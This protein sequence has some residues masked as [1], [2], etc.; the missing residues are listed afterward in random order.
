VGLGS[1]SGVFQWVQHLWYRCKEGGKT[2]RGDVVWG[3]VGVVFATVGC[4]REIK[5]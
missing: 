5:R 1:L 4:D 2:G 3:C